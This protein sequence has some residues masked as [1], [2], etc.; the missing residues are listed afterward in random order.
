MQA[1]V[2]FKGTMERPKGN[3]DGIQLHFEKEIGF[4]CRALISSSE[5]LL[6]GHPH[7]TPLH[8]NTI[9]LGGKSQL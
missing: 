6:G 4:S 7:L 1:D 5:D 2:T 9:N 3:G 8:P